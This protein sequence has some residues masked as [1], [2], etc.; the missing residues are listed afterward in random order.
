MKPIAEIVWAG[1][2]EGSIKDVSFYKVPSP[3][4]GTKLYTHP[5]K[6]LSRELLDKTIID[7][8]NEI[9][10]LRKN[11]DVALM[12][13]NKPKLTDE[14]IMDYVEAFSIDMGNYYEFQPD[15]V[16]QMIRAILDEAQEK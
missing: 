4:V 15:N 13:V 14:E 11:L 10:D 2:I 5:V 9:K 12:I 3:D 1:G 8:Q 16:L 6:E 7:Q